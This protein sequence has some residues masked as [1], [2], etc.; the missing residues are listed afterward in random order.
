MMTLDDLWTTFKVIDTLNGVKM[1]KYSLVTTPT[2]CR[3]AGCIISVKP[4]YSCA[5][6]LTC[7][8]TAECVGEGILKT[9][10]YLMNL[11][12][13]L[14]NNRYVTVFI[15]RTCTKQTK[16]GIGIKCH[17]NNVSHIVL[18]YT[19][20]NTKTWSLRIF[21]AAFA[22]GLIFLLIDV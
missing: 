4:M 14:C 19:S 18:W 1:A 5:G 21:I 10:E 11:W 6:L 16:I 17:C 12:Q 22:N 13:N 7:K 8:F 20:C 3:V 15:I 2:L 9:G